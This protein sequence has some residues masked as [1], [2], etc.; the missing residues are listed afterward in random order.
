MRALI[1][2]IPSRTANSKQEKDFI[3][4][5]KLYNKYLIYLVC[6]GSRGTYMYDI[7][8]YLFPL[9]LFQ[10]IYFPFCIVSHYDPIQQRPLIL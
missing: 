9:V 4:I 2:P 8:I 7:F 3:P 5:K 6:L 10:N 1:G